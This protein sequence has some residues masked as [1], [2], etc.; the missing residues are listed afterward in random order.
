MIISCFFGLV[1][2][3][4]NFENFILNIS[5]KFLCIVI[6]FIIIIQFNIINIDIIKKI[7]NKVIKIINNSK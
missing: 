3:S 6:F 5:T 1:G 4:F 2:Y 7:K